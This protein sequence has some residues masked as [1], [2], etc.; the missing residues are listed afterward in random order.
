MSILNLPR[1]KPSH[2]IL[3][4]LYRLFNLFP[5][6]K[7]KFKFLLDLEWIF[8]RLALEESFKLYG[9]HNPVIREHSVKTILNNI[10]ETDKVLDLGCKFGYLTS[11]IAD[12]ALHVVGID[13]EEKAIEKA[14][15]SYKQENLTFL[16]AEAIEYIDK[17]DTSFNTLILS[18]ILE[19][20]DRPSEFLTEISKRFKKIYIE[21]PDFDANFLNHYRLNENSKLIFSDSDHIN[22]FDRNDMINLITDV[23]L[24][25]HSSEY[26]FGVQ[27]YW[28]YIN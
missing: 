14:K 19:H 24:K 26:I 23:G 7:R 2:T 6:S 22:E 13:Y 12:R 27:K 15:S 11:K 16:V 9:D 3:R 1:N 17:S 20:L 4:L 10:D 8:Y 5:S 25:I 18:H 28:C 21:L